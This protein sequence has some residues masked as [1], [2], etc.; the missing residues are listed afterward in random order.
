VVFIEG[1]LEEFITITQNFVIDF[2]RILKEGMK[3]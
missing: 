1:N 2:V 3:F